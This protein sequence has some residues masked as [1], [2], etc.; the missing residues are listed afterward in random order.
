LFKRYPRIASS[1]VLLV[2][3]V[4]VSGV[5]VSLAWR[6][7][8]PDAETI[9]RKYPWDTT[10]QARQRDIAI[11]HKQNFLTLLPIVL[12]FSASLLTVAMNMY[13]FSTQFLI[14]RDVERL[15]RIAEKS[16]PAFGQLFGAATN[17]YRILAP[18]QTGNFNAEDV[19]KAEDRMK[20]VEGVTIF[21]TEQYRNEWMT[22]WQR[23]RFHKEYINKNI[24]QENRAKYWPTVAKDLGAHINNLQRL[25]T[26]YFET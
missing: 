3:L 7:S 24:Q 15:K 17:Y 22:F 13:I 10:D 6:F 5:F 12:T 11:E 16:I 26:T 25:A 2:I 1:L 8:A 9:Y 18:L 14:T 20:E 4:L 23:A 19:E 21:V